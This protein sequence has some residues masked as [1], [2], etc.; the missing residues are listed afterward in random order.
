MSEYHVVWEID[1][2]ADSPEAA[3]ET[4]RT[5]MRDPASLAS[6]FSVTEEN[7][8]TTVIVDLEDLG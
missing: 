2:S 7:S 8:D 6:V 5:I 4:A 1:V 3:A